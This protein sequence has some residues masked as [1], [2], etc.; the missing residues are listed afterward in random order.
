MSAVRRRG[1][2]LI[3]GGIVGVALSPGA[4]RVGMGVRA[5]MTRLGRAAGDPVSPFLAA[6]C[7]EHDRVRAAEAERAGAAR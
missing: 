1:G 6:P 5:R 7:Y 4:R 2:W 3:A